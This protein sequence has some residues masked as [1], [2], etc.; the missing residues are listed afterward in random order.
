MNISF[1][2]SEIDAGTYNITIDDIH[3]ASSTGVDLALNQVTKEFTVFEIQK[4]DVNAD[5]EVN[6]TDVVAIVNYILGKPNSNFNSNAADLNND[7]EINVTDVVAVV[8]II[9]G[10]PNASSRAMSR[11]MVTDNDRMMLEETKDGLSLSLDNQERYV[12]AQMDVRLSDV[13]TLASV[14]LN[15]ERKSGHQLSWSE[16]GD[17]HYRVLAYSI[18]CNSFLGHSGELMSFMTEGSGEVTIENITLVTGD[19]KVKHFAD[20]N[21]YSRGTT[22][23]DAIDAQV[24]FPADIYD[25]SGRLLYKDATTIKNLNSGVYIINGKKVI[26]K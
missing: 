9:L 18:G 13:Q 16:I 25:T 10:R 12:A 24:D 17:G 19:L 14:A 23:I 8:N 21:S 7:G 5:G 26:I 11:A 4:G 3:L 2:T 1:E 15:Q 6:V 20:L 22:G